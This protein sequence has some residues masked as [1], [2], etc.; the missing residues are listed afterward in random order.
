MKASFNVVNGG[1][2]VHPRDEN[3]KQRSQR[4]KQRS[5]KKGKPKA[6]NSSNKQQPK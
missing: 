2:G 5:S 1:S 4:E 6:L 3:Q